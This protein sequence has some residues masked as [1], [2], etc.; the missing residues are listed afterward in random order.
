MTR[1]NKNG[2]RYTKMLHHHIDISVLLSGQELAFC[3]HNKAKGSSN[4][5]KFLE[6]M[7]L[8]ASYSHELRSILDKEH[9]TYT[10]HD[11]QND[12]ID[13][14]A[15][16]K[17][18]EIQNRIHTSNFIAIMMDDTSDISNVEQSA[19]S[20]RLIPRGEVE[21]HLLGLIDMTDDQSA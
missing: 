8:L 13:C 6:L 2:S 9:V 12:L 7:D 21:E 10:S 14:I 20:V 5:G 19:V 18:S 4:R 11:S 1:H 17:R 3:A 15:E 16:E